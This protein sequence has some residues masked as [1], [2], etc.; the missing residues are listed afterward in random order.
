MGPYDPTTGTQYNSFKQ[1]AAARSILGLT[2]ANAVEF[3]LVVPTA[4]DRPSLTNKQ[5]AVRNAQPTETSPGVWEYGW[6]VEDIP[7]AEL[8]A[9]M[10]PLSRAQFAGALALSGAV[11]AGEARAWGKN[12][13]LPSFAITAIENS[14]MTD[15]E[16]LLATIKAESA[17]EI[18]RT[19]P[20]VA[21]LQAAKSLTDAQ[22]D[23]LFI[24]GAAL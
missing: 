15:D 22:V 23:A 2:E 17:T 13:D 16:K 19:S 21:L 1:A 12:G 18:D 10:A 3:G 8:R 14:G 5:I 11:T 20:I 9:N 24:T 7:D 4:A 6:T